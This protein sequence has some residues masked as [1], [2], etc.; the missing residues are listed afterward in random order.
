MR[1]T[2]G[3]LTGRNLRTANSPGLRPTKDMVR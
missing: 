2:G 3:T 1:I